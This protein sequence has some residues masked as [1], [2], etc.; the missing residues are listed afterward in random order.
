VTEPTHRGLRGLARPGDLERARS[1][2]MATLL[3]LLGDRA[4]PGDRAEDVLLDL[5]LVDERAF[6]FDLARRAGRALVGLRG[7]APDPKLFLYVPL[8]TAAAQ[9]VCPLVLVGDSLKVASAYLD[10]DLLGVETRFPNLELELVVAVRSELLA[11]LLQ[12]RAAA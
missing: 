7:F 5:G 4:R 3:R 9:K 11:A 10:P 2:Q 8:A 1:L 6:A 12:A